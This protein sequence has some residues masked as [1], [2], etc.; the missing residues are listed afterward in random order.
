MYITA[1]L[2]ALYGQFNQIKEENYPFRSAF[3]G[4]LRALS[5]LGLRQGLTVEELI[6]VVEDTLFLGMRLPDMPKGTKPVKFRFT[7]EDEV[8]GE[9]FGKNSM[10]NKTIIM[11]IIRMTLR[12][13]VQY[14]TSLMRLTRLVKQVCA[15]EAGNGE[16]YPQ[17]VDENYPQSVD[18]SADKKENNPHPVDNPVDMTDN[19]PQDADNFVD[20]EESGEKP[21]IRITKA[22]PPAEEKKP[23]D[24]IGRL[25]ELV[26]RGDKLLSDTAGN[27]SG[28]V[29]ETN[30]LLGDF[31]G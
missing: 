22:A 16:R 17:L 19:N 30:P 29:I 2:P 14:G 9:Y 5:E 10:A 27:D 3:T 6:G 7:T 12:L 11:L 13:S 24:V 31:F 15:R 1:N 18:N 21:K 25:S 26:E 23:A 20:K 28:A 8:I 4:Y